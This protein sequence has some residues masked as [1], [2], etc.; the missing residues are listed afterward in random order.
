MQ[1]TPNQSAVGLPA[2][3]GRTGGIR[4]LFVEDDE[5]Y[6]EALG[7]DLSERGFVIQ[8]FAD[9]TSLLDSFGSAAEVIILDWKLPRTSGIDL[10]GQLRRQGVNLPVMFLTGLASTVHETLAFDRGAIDFIDKSRG[11]DVLVSRLKRIVESYKPIA[12]RRAD[13]FIACGKLVL[14]PEISRA[15]WNGVDVGLTIGEYKI[16][17]LLATSAGR[18]ITYRSIYDRL[19]YE[20]F[21]AG[22]GNTGYRTN[23]RS[24]IRRIRNKFRACDPAFSE[25]ENHTAF[26][27]CWGSPAGDSKEGRVV[28]GLGRELEGSED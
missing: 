6:R 10:L 25:I 21:I 27:Y 9:A 19:T 20:G 13:K 18:Y 28:Q 1:G 26:G 4:I 17:H 2:Y 12:D 24:A 8:S 22:V 11:V 14:K 7:A 23:V 3:V 16:V 5:D 15:Y